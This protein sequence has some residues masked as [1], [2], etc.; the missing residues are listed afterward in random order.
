MQGALQ[1][2]DA[3]VIGTIPIVV[4]VLASGLFA[5]LGGLAGGLVGY[6]KSKSD[7]Q[8][9]LREYKTRVDCNGCVLRTEI[10]NMK[11]DGDGLSKDLKEHTK[12]LTQVCV[13]IKLLAQKQDQTLEKIAELK[14][15]LTK[16]S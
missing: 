3:Q 10:D 13:D 8:V 14:T 12:K 5:V 2:A 6:Y 7:F 16:D 11:S 1:M 15:E 9:D 4:Y